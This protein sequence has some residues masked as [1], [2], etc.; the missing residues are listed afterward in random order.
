MGK[1]LN[2]HVR[3]ISTRNKNKTKDKKQTNQFQMMMKTRIILM[4]W[5]LVLSNL[6]IIFWMYQIQNAQ[7]E[8]A[9]PMILVIQVAK[10]SMKRTFCF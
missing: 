3:V 9:M 1:N 5:T 4:P 10:M 6:S 8:G 2:D 7:I